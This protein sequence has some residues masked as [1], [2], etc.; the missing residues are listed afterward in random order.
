MRW[1]V[2]VMTVRPD[3]VVLASEMAALE[4]ET[5]EVNDYVGSDVGVL[6]GST[7]T[8]SCSTTTSTTSTTSTSG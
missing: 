4:S 5:F 7:S 8:T 6:L 1:G 2:K 3:L